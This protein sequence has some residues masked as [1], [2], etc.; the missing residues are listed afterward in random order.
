VDK[1]KVSVSLVQ[2]R[3][4]IGYNRA[5]RIVEWMERD[6]IVAPADGAKPRDV[7][8]GEL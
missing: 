1:G 8:V 6:G 5:A 7:I 2:R 3:F 4:R